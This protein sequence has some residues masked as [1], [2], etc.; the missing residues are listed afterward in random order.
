MSVIYALAT[1][2]AQSAICVFRVSG[3]GCLDAL[4]KLFNSDL[5]EPRF[6]YKT[7]MYDKNSFV[8]SVAVV[9]F[10]GPNSFTGE[11][12]LRFMLTAV[13]VMS[14]LLI[15]SNLL[16][17]ERLNQVSFLKGVLKQQNFSISG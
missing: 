15:V 13:V 3:D 8:D 1:P 16:V 14:K 4:P 17:L 5:K 11:D 6:F 7:N 12:G 10:K 9:F 2:A